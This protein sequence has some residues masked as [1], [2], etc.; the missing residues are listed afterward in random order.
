MQNT[1]S[2]ALISAQGLSGN[3]EAANRSTDN[4]NRTVFGRL[5][6]K[7]WRVVRQV[8]VAIAVIMPVLQLLLVM[9]S[10]GILASGGPRED[11]LGPTVLITMLAPT[12]IALGCSGMLI[13]HERQTGTWGWSSVLPTSWRSALLSKLI[14]TFGACLL[15]FCLT[16]TIPLI[17]FA[18]GQLPSV[19]FRSEFA[20]FPLVLFLV[21][22][23][24]IAF[25]YLALLLFREP[26]VALVVGAFAVSTAQLIVIGLLTRATTDFLIRTGL[27]ATRETAEV[28]LMFSLGTLFFLIGTACM[29][30]AFRWRWTYGQ[31]TPLGVWR[32]SLRSSPAKA[33]EYRIRKNVSPTELGSQFVLAFRQMLGLRLLVITGVV[34]AVSWLNRYELRDMLSAVVFQAI[35]ILGATTFAGDQSLGRF[36]FLADRGVSPAKLVTTRLIVAMG[37]VLV[38]LAA[39]KLG[40]SIGSPRFGLELTGLASPELL[41]LAFSIGAL[42]SLCFRR[43]IIAVTVTVILLGFCGGALLGLYKDA[44]N[45]MSA[46]M[47]RDEIFYKLY[48]AFVL[49]CAC[50]LIAASYKIANRWVVQ[51]RVN[52]GLRYVAAFPLA[53]LV[54]GLALLH[55]G[56]LLQPSYDPK[57]FPL[58]SL[59]HDLRKIPEIRD[60]RDLFTA[61]D[62]NEWTQATDPRYGQ[63]FNGSTSPHSDAYALIV[64]STKEKEATG[65][66]WIEQAKA[67]LSKL[68]DRIS[69][70]SSSELNLHKQVWNWN[71]LL[72]KLAIAGRLASAEGEFEL[73]KQ[74]WQRAKQLLDVN[75]DYLYPFT[76]EGRSMVWWALSD[77]TDSEIA[78]L[79]GP[80]AVRVLCPK[81]TPEANQFWQ[82]SLIHT[83][84]KLSAI[85]GELPGHE[86]WKNLFDGRELPWYIL[87]PPVK[88][89]I[90]RT[91]AADYH[92]RM[93]PGSFLPKVGYAAMVYHDRAGEFLA[94]LDRL[95]AAADQSDQSDR[96]DRTDL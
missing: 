48:A 87:Y 47:L 22:F 8:V 50:V 11:V 60:Q 96:T 82:T 68:D 56:F 54:S 94:R 77:L 24:I 73:S 15:L 45:G 90:M 17:L 14:V 25:F 64:Q 44:R 49:G 85:N 13:G 32:G 16:A 69:W 93:S 61:I 4:F 78:G 83:I 23:E 9:L 57:E 20:L 27:V 80:Q 5:L 51:D 37:F 67:D 12:L 33:I 31:T 35:G 29:V 92:N 89:F 81:L 41:L 95:Q 30:W 86:S 65:V 43:P 3:N 76:Q 91:V 66:K 34:P 59:E 40:T 53:I 6:W 18:S 28:V 63:T 58:A 36:R 21:W 62:I 79:G 75:S 74:A 7:D 38:G 1:V 19:S 52:L 84:L 72:A 10:F 88:W 2:E 26:L 39:C 55:V 46:S 42:G 70:T 71:P